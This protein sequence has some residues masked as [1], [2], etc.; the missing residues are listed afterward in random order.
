MTQLAWGGQGT[1]DVTCSLSIMW[2][3][4]TQNSGHQVLSK[5]DT[6]VHH[7]CM[8]THTHK[9]HNY[10]HITYV[11]PHICLYLIHDTC[12]CVATYIPDMHIYIHTANTSHTYYGF[13]D[14]SQMWLLWPLLFPE[15]P[16]TSLSMTA[17]HSVQRK[18]TVNI[19]SHIPPSLCCCPALGKHALKLGQ[20][21]HWD[22]MHQLGRWVLMIVV[23]II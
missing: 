3:L 20:M 14:H 19:P 6:A 23:E 9:L 10:I 16:P 8:H 12:I 15:R 11:H 21:C 4:G 7:R 17:C 22:P 18:L 2:V 1:Y 5:T 13:Y